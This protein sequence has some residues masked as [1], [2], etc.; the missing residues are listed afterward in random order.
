MVDGL[1]GKYHHILVQAGY[2]IWIQ[3]HRICTSI[4]FILSHVY[5]ITPHHCIIYASYD[6]VHH[7]VNL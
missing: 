5:P 2:K 1:H 3:N 6:M 4:G 7:T